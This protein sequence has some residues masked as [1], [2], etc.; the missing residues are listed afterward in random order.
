MDFETL[1]LIQRLA[2]VVISRHQ[3]EEPTRASLDVRRKGTRAALQISW[4][5]GKAPEYDRLIPLGNLLDEI[6]M[7]LRLE[8][9]RVGR[10]IFRTTEPLFEGGENP[11]YRIDI[12]RSE[13]DDE[14]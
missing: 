4:Q 14:N 11:V 1:A 7:E 13:D 3:R 8:K 9:D 2:F 12:L 6:I 5:P 10:Q